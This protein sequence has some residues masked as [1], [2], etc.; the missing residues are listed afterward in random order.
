MLKCLSHS[1]TVWHILSEALTL[2]SLTH[3]ASALR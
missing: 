1:L 3:G 2:E